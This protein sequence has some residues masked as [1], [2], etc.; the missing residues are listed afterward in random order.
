VTTWN[1]GWHPLAEVW[2][3]LAEDALRDLATSI[4][5]HGQN[6]PCVMTPDGLGLD[7]RN[8]VTA[9]ALAGVEPTWRVYD[10]DPMSFA[11]DQSVQ[12]RHLTPSQLAMGVVISFADAGKLTNGR[13][14]KGEIASR[15]EF[16]PRGFKRFDA[17]LR[18]AGLVLDYLGREE[19]E[20]VLR[21]D[22]GLGPAADRASKVKSERE[23]IKALGGDL[24]ALVEG[25]VIDVEEAVRRAS[26]EARVSQLAPDLA[27]RVRD[28]ALDVGEAE[29]IERDRAERD[30]IW[31]AEIR[32]ALAALVPM[33]DGPIPDPFK[34]ALTEDEYGDLRVALQ[35]I[36][37]RH[38]RV[39]R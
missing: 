27:E 25:G 11:L 15:A 6:E 39:Q 4:V 9:C 1:G 34:E 26:V 3:L 8:R 28:G 22:V 32:S 17:R 19:A 38:E 12:R 36:K 10:G 21:G 29:T 30:S 20:A 37:R 23:R 33:A 24:A 16:G 31:F 14:P 13:V 2:P 18:E 7:G 5:E 35:A